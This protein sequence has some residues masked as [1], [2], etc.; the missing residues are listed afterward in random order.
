MSQM[1]PAESLQAL[2]E[3]RKLIQGEGFHDASTWDEFVATALAWTAQEAPALL[4]RLRRYEDALLGFV[5]ACDNHPPTDL[6]NEIS[7]Q[8]EIARNAL[9][10]P[11]GGLSEGQ[12]AAQAQP[13]KDKQ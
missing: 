9:R 8:C 11:E 4:E 6:M 5:S 12:P 10:S 7:R 13:E 2:I 1:T 3:K